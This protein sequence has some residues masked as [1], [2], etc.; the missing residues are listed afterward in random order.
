MTIYEII[1]AIL[2][3]VNLV[4]FFM[5]ASK[6]K[7]LDVK[8]KKLETLAKTNVKNPKLARKLLNQYDK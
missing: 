7:K 8:F 3:S 1:N 2:V 4:I 5:V 6:I